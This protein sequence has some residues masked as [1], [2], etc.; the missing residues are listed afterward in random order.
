MKSKDPCALWLFLTQQSMVVLVKILRTLP[1]GVLSSS[2]QS[3]GV[4]LTRFTAL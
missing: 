4:W 2:P 3:G 1:A